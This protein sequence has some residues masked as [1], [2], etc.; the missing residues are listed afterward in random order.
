MVNGP[1]SGVMGEAASLRSRGLAHAKAGEFD[2]AID[3]FRR[4]RLLAPAHFPTLINLGA[5]YQALGHHN[6]ALAVLNEALRLDSSRAE[7]FNN[8]AVSLRALR[9]LE[10]SVDNARRALVLRPDYPEALNNL[11]AAQHEL[12]AMTEAILSFKAAIKLNPSYGKALANLGYVLQASG[13]M[14]ASAE[15]FARAATHEPGIDDLPGA[16]LHADLRLCNWEGLET[17]TE[18]LIAAI[19]QGHRVA[20]PFMVM[21]LVDDPELHRLAA[22]INSAKWP[23]AAR[24]ESTCVESQGRI[25]IGYFSA[26]YFNHATTHLLTGLIEQHDRGQFEVMGFSLGPARTD[27]AGQRIRAAFDRFFCIHEMDDAAAAELSRSLGVNIAIDL[28][29]Y[30]QDSRPGIF[31]ARAAPIQTS[32]LGYPGTLAMPAMDYL[33][34]DETLVPPTMR[35]HYDESIVFMPHSYQC[36]DRRA[37]STNRGAAPC[38]QSLDLPED[39]FV[40]CCFNNSFKILPAVFDLWLDILKECEHSV[41]WLLLDNATAVTRLRSA[42]ERGGVDP[43]RLVFAARTTVD[44][45]LARHGAADLFLDTTPYNAHTTASDALW[46]GVPVLTQIGRSFPAR[47]AA[48]LLHAVDLPELVTQS[49]EEYRARAI[50]LA[51]NPADLGKLRARLASARH[52]SPLFDP[53]TF[54][55]NLESAFIVMMDRHRRDQPPS[56]IK[57]PSRKN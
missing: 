42:A 50:H 16:A 15:C 3:C 41:L 53:T 39:A 34:A 29:G 24:P 4:A 6:D 25:R 33:I 47:V 7:L 46:M 23:T 35:S 5:A 44:A 8:L 56:D 48:S 32:F 54:A 20:S 51:K 30:T 37:A 43:A 26:D 19:R 57:I 12:G 21:G 52:A 27:S 13:D 10:E 49:P 40:F 14:Q 1:E 55:R 45:H 17:R 28:K 22:R 2:S 18:S 38:R 36:N 11:G 9:R 31:A